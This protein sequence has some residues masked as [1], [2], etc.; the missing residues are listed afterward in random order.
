MVERDLPANLK[1]AQSVKPDLREWQK[2]PTCMAK[3]TYIL[4]KRDVLTRAY[5]RHKLG[6]V[7]LRTAHLGRKRAPEKPFFVFE[8]GGLSREGRRE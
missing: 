8:R 5:L 4:G 6:N 2:R 7:G 1:Y 3:E